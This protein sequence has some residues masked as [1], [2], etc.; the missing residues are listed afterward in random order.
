M[1]PETDRDYAG[2]TVEEEYGRTLQRE[3]EAELLRRRLAVTV[4]EADLYPGRGV[5]RECSA[6]YG[7]YHR[8]GCSQIPG[9]VRALAVR[10]CRPGECWDPRC[11]N[12]RGEAASNAGR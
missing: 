1:D 8:E 7:N 4:V 11:T 2:T 5:C 10:Y 3:A 6:L 12:Y 9:S